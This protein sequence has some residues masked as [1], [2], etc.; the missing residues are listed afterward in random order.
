MKLIFYSADLSTELDLPFATEG[1]R[2]GF[3]SPAQDYMTD[4]IDLNKEL[5]LHPATTFYARAVGNSMTGFGISDGDLLVIDKSIEPVDGDI[6]VAFIDGE[7]TLKKIMKDEN[8]CNLWL[9]P[10]N[11]DYPPIKITEEN[12][13]IVWGVLTYN[14]KRQLIRSKRKRE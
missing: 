9:V 8:E 1:I 12:D 13:F 10:G 11:E 14:I 6:V 3:P 2:A 7:F 5:V 4:S